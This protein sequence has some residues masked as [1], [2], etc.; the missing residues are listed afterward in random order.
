[1]IN[2]ETYE[3]QVCAVD[4]EGY[5]SM[6]SNAMVGRPIDFP[7]DLGFLV[8]DETRDGNGSAFSPTDVQVDDFYDDA[9]QGFDTQ[10]ISIRWLSTIEMMARHPLIL[11]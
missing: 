5:L 2:G 6:P 3:Y 1:M 4:V 10:W 11:A 7:F 8:V 9:L